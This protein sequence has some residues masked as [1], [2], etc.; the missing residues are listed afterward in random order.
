VAATAAETIARVKPSIV[1]GGTFE[2]ERAPA[3]EFRGTGFAVDD[4]KTIAT[5]AH[6]LPELLDPAKKETVAVLVATAAGEPQM[7]A[8]KTVAIDKE[9]DLALLR[10]DG[11]PLPPLRLAE[12]DTVREGQEV[13][14]TGF[15]L[16]PILGFHPATHRG[17]IAAITPIAIPQRRAAELDAAV[18]RRLARGVF[19]V[20]Q[21][22]ATA[23]PGNSGSPVYD[24]ATGAVVGI[25]NMVFVK[26]M[27]ESAVTH[28]SGITYAVP[29]E[30]LRK[31]LSHN[32]ALRDEPRN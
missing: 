7:R 3:F 32:A 25:V 21:L 2:R 22:D 19:P 1:A 10:I 9:V 23:Y 6:V 13:L 8:A 5:N 24:A 15:P 16:G 18:V 4:G 17:M 12:G 26:G 14:L 30:H 31:L 20:Y 27:K 28:P 11:A 29:S